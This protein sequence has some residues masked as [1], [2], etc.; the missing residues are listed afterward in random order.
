MR[1]TRPDRQAPASTRPHPLTL[2]LGSGYPG[3]EGYSR[4]YD[5]AL[6]A[7]RLGATLHLEGPVD[8][9]AMGFYRLLFPLHRHAEPVAFRA[10]VL[11]ALL[12]YDQR[13]NSELIDTLEAYSVSGCNVVEA[14]DRLHVHRNSLAYRLRRIAE[15]TSRDLHHQEDLFLLQ[16]ALKIHRVLQAVGREA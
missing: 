2:S 10:E 11:D 5:E 12:S 15:I 1:A 7:L 9:V 8:F 14:A 16:L 6:Y 4:A 3:L 13:R